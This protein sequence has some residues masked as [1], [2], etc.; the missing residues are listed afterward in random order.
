[1]VELFAS[2]TVVLIVALAGLALTSVAIVRDL[3][4]SLAARRM[5]V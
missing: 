1:M 5:E 2:E 4:A 3:G